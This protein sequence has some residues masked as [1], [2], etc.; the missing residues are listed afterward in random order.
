ML[1]KS[2]QIIIFLKMKG[3]SRDDGQVDVPW[4]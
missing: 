3:V 2:Q 4:C 1:S